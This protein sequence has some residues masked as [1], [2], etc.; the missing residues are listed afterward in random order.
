MAT[1]VNINT[2]TV[3]RGLHSQRGVVRKWVVDLARTTERNAIRLAPVNEVEN[4]Q[5]RGG[6]VGTYKASFGISGRGSNQFSTQRTVY[7]SADH[8]NIVEFGRRAVF[9]RQRFSWTVWGGD[10]RSVTRTEG[11]PGK[12][13]LERAARQAAARKRVPRAFDRSRTVTFERTF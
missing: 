2:A 3:Y 9:G 5:H 13:V 1:K 4:A 10:I 7:N 8:A 12:R 11:R 6:I